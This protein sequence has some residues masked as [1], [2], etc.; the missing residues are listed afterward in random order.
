MKFAWA[1]VLSACLWDISLFAQFDVGIVL[2]FE[3]K[4]RDPQLDWIGESFVEVLSS[5]L[6]SARFLMQG[7]RERTAAFDTLG[8]PNTSI[9][10]DATIYKVAQTL[11]ATKVI[12]GHFDY[13]NGLFKAAAQVLDMEGPSLSKEFSES[14]P[15][16]KLIE[17]QTG[18]A[19]QILSF[20]RPDIEVSKSEF[21]PERPGPR[22]EAFENYL[23]GLISKNRA[24]QIR[25]FRD[26][27]RL[28]S[29][30]AKPA[31]ELGM[32]YFHYRDYPTSVLWLAKLRRSD[33]DY[34]EASYF[35]GLAYLYL[36][37]YE[38]SAA[39][40]RVVAQ[41]LPLNEVYNNLGIALMRQDRPGAIAYFEKAIESQPADPD[42]QFNLGYALWKQERYAQAVS[43]LRKALQNASHPAW[44]VIYVQCL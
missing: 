28:D 37:Q 21:V 42:F 14:G 7:R 36:E 24:D 8:I 44:R 38:R 1:I 40:F 26:A 35:L 10:S 41:Q 11:D 13:S 31:F 15:L 4:S 16:A 33:A 5:D 17:L 29:Q 39:A 6:A 25:Y 9:L 18:L 23:R 32:I 22:L 27:V 34:L 2:P 3:N 12:L 30:F 20:L 43:H 19:W